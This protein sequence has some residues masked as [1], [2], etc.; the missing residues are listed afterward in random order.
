[1]DL[2]VYA[3]AIRRHG[4][5]KTTFHFQIRYKSDKDFEVLFRVKY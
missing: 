3:A 1:M 2:R 5:D 4:V